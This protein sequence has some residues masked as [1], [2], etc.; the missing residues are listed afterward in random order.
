VLWIAGAERGTP[1][2]TN[3]SSPPTASP[4]PAASLPAYRP[5]APPALVLGP[6]FAAEDA[7]KIQTFPDWPFAFRTP[8]AM[9]C[10]AGS[11]GSGAS[12]YSCRQ[13]DQPKHVTL[14]L[15][16]R[17]ATSGCNAA[18]LGQLEKLAPLA[19]GSTFVSSGPVTRYADTSLAASGRTQFTLV[20]CF[21]GGSG[22][23]PT[24]AIIYQGNAPTDQRELILKIAND[25][26]SQTG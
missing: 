5:D 26:R 10:N 22:R 2:A 20:H 21:G 11:G 24:S 1:S 17:K 19:P 12:T 3:S 13:G 8:P 16:L 18:E 7:T 25:I 4:T 15:V 23:P 14:A 9:T 6:T